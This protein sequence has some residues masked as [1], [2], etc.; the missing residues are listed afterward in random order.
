MSSSPPNSDRE[1][2]RTSSKRSNNRENSKQGSAS[3]KSA[4][5][6]ETVKSADGSHKKTNGENVK[7]AHTSKGKEHKVGSAPASPHQQKK[8][9]K[10]RSEA[11][12][13]VP[14]AIEK[15]KDQHDPH[16][17]AGSLSPTV[18]RAGTVQQIDPVVVKYAGKLSPAQIKEFKEAFSIFDKNGDGGISIDELQI[19]LETLGQQPTEKEVAEMMREVDKDGN[20]EIDFDEFL[21]MMVKMVNIEDKEEDVTKMFAC[22]DP[23]KKGYIEIAEFMKVFTTFGDALPMK[24]VK[25]LV[26]LVDKTP[27][28]HLQFNSLVKLLVS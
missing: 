25:E 8:V 15:A 16:V 5:K 18:P 26:N 10:S 6:L 7:R 27:E 17:R 4:T 11:V 2:S 14:I 3:P 13:P 24:D 22:L 12:T 28:G 23:Q 9:K 21:Q 1:G 20:N 19:F